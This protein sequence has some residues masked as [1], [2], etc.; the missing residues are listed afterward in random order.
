MTKYEPMTGAEKA[1]FTCNLDN[2]IVMANLL[3]RFTFA[4]QRICEMESL[5][6]KLVDSGNAAIK[7]DYSNWDSCCEEA[8]N[9]AS[10]QH[11]GQEGER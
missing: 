6:H 1:N 3:A 5:I 8:T 11:A 2:P 10:P 7:G 9:F 4:E